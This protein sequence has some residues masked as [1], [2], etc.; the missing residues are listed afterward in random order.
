MGTKLKSGAY[1]WKGFA[2]WHRQTEERAFGY[3]WRRA[4]NP[5]LNIYYTGR[6]E[7]DYGEYGNYKDADGLTSEEVGHALY[8]ALKEE[9]LNVLWDGNADNSIEVFPEEF[10]EEIEMKL[11]GSFGY[12]NPDS[13]LIPDYLREKVRESRNAYLEYSEKWNRDYKARRLKESMEKVLEAMEQSYTE[14]KTR[15]KERNFW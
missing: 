2:F 11:H 9:G 1:K 8:N 3:G 13:P 15:E 14:V 5:K 7:L 12:L 10:D 4:D 6:N